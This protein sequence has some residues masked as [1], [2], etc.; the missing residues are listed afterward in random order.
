MTIE[1]DKAG[2]FAGINEIVESQKKQA[3][4]ARKEP[5]SRRKERL[6]QI[7]SWILKNRTQIQEAI[8]ADFNKPALEVDGTEIFPAL[9]EVSVALSNLKIWTKPRKIDAPL[10]M[11]GT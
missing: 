6:K 3:L 2:I 11:L 7:Q 9:T 4:E 10:T 5:I 8:Y 1:L